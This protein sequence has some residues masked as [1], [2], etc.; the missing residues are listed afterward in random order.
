SENIRGLL[1]V[2]L[3]QPPHA[4]PADLGVR[5]V[6][7]GLEQ[8][9]GALRGPLLRHQEHGLAAEGNRTLVPPRDHFPEDGER[10]IRIHLQERVERR[11]PLV[12]VL[13]G[14][15][16]RHVGVAPR[17]SRGPHTRGLRAAPV[18]GRTGNA[19]NTRGGG[20]T[21]YARDGGD[22][23]LSRFGGLCRL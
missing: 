20:G 4:L 22:G 19:G 14:T 2:Y 6:A 3:A 17:R 12:I 5:I 16:G 18:L 15:P 10:P 13:A 8:N 11:D 9:V 7:D 1:S 21:R 23:R